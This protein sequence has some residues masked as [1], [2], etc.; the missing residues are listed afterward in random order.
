MSL[1][2]VLQKELPGTPSVQVAAFLVVLG[3]AIDVFTTFVHERNDPNGYW[4]DDTPIGYFFYG[5]AA[6]LLVQAM[7]VRTRAPRNDDSPDGSLTTAGPVADKSPVKLSKRERVKL[8][9][10]QFSTFLQ[11]RKFSYLSA[12]FLFL[13]F[14]VM[15]S[16]QLSKWPTYGI[17]VHVVGAHI[18]MG[19]PSVVTEP[20][21]VQ[22][23][24]GKAK[25]TREIYLNGARVTP[26]ELQ[27]ELRARFRKQPDWLVYVEGDEKLAFSDVAEVMDIISAFHAEIVIVPP[28]RSVPAV[29]QGKR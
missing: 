4:R 3:T 25:R 18:H 13:M 22:L 14:V 19:S 1:R 15:A 26:Q 2:E 24:P 21:L 11:L 9:L 29:V 20:L 23:K 5:F 27:A 28:N 7:V 16:L 10:P 8:P 6:I 12:I 17:W